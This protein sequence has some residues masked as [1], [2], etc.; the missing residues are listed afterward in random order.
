MK[1]LDHSFQDCKLL[2]NLFIRYQEILTQTR[3][4]NE[5]VYAICC[6]PG[7]P[8]DVISRGNVET[9][10]GYPWMNFGSA[11]FSS[12]RENQNQPFA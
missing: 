4:K 7:V 5:H 11:T 8:G 1:F 2:E 6:R 3:P 10:E 12:F 9:I